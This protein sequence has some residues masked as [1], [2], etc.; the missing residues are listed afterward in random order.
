MVVPA[1]RLKNDL[2]PSSSQFLE[3]SMV[4]EMMADDRGCCWNASID[5]DDRPTTT[6]TASSKERDKFM[7]GLQLS[8]GVKKNTLVPTTRL[9]RVPPR[10]RRFCSTTSMSRRVGRNF[11]RGR[12]DAEIIPELPPISGDNTA[13]SELRSLDSAREEGGGSSPPPT[14]NLTP[15]HRSTQ[16]SAT[17]REGGTRRSQS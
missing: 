16:P 17:Q 13:I 3:C 9:N 7:A 8:M 15:T 2:L 12:G 14:N 11:P 10:H 1:L 5:T 6:D 4:L